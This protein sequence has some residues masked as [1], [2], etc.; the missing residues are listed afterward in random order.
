MFTIGLDTSAL[1][2]KFKSHAMRGIGRYVFELSRYFQSNA[3]SRIQV[4]NFDHREFKD[5]GLLNKMIKFLP[6]GRQTIRQQIVYPFSLS[7]KK[8]SYDYLHFPAHMDAPAWSLGNY[9]LTVLDL[10]PLVLSD[11]YKAKKPGWRFNFARWLEIKSIKNASLILA[12]S[13]NTAR[14]VCRLLKV[15]R[16]RIVVTPLGVDSSFFIELDDTAKTALKQK[17]NIPDRRAL[18]V[19]VGGIDPRKNYSALIESFH[20]LLQIYREKNLTE[21]ALLLV[22]SIKTDREYAELKK[23]ITSKEL[24]NYIFETGF[25]ADQDLP[26]IYAVSDVLFFPSLYEGFGLTPLEAMAAG[27]PVLS[28]NTSCMPDILGD[29]ALYVDPHDHAKA[30]DILFDLLNN[31]DTSDLKERAK[32]RAA[33]YS[34]SKTGELTMAAYESLI[35]KNYDRASQAG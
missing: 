17:Y 13:E 25:I 8:K 12:I 30:A 18:I 1:D 7:S 26:G 28:S 3:N 2:L 11:L 31:M 33:L 6:A 34:W 5:K 10:I 15:P 9:V 19:S 20:R 4:Q 32:K 29:A 24:D 22:G 14:D 27:T 21:P 35:A 23:Q 16:E